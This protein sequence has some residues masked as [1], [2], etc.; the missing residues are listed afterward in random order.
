MTVLTL[1]TDYSDEVN[2][3][4]YIIYICRDMRVFLAPYVSKC[5]VNQAKASVPTVQEECR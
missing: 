1:S 5:H 3:D 4:I 2:D